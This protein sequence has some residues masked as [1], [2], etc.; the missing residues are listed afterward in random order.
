MSIEMPY[1]VILKKNFLSYGI[2][3]DQNHRISNVTPLP[4]PPPAPDCSE[5]K[6]SIVHFY[7]TGFPLPKGVWFD[8]VPDQEDR[9]L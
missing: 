6:E 9:D 8:S 2:Q 1:I 7:R 5:K 4:P 3:T